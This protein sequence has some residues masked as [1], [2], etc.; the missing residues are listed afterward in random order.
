MKYTRVIAD[1]WQLTIE[2]KKLVWFTFVPSFIGVVVFIA[3]ILWQYF[4]LSEEFGRVEQGYVFEK[5]G[6]IFSVLTENSLLG[7][8]IFFLLFVLLFYFLLPAWIEATL[9]MGVKHRYDHPEKK[10][11]LR[12][13]IIEGFDYFFEIFE[14]RAATSPFEL[15]TI[16][17]FTLTF[18][19]YYHGDVFN[20]MLPLIIGYGIV[21]LFI[22]VL[23][24]FSP[25]Y[26]VLEDKKFS[27]S[28][29]KSISLVFLNIGDTIGLY[30]LMLL[31]NVRVIVNVVVIF[32]V[33]ALI[34]GVA[35]Y[36][37]G[38]GW[39]N[40]FVILGTLVGIVM[41]SLSAY[42]NAILEVF[43]VAFWTKAFEKLRAKQDE[44]SSTIKAP[45]A[46]NQ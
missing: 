19:R 5:I 35:T 12:Q 18:Y 25:Y 34:F 45:N 10:F 41:I 37:T 23:L 4:F 31:I 11:S 27:P 14:I 8:G 40:F 30:L 28:I 33:P 13:K 46:E 9:I 38:S 15:T 36:F 42:L 32:G 6:Q 16:A 21:A 2:N 24:T 3:E 43:A 39:Q 22:S 26:A 7:V 44:L 20:F 29:R 1:A 17:F